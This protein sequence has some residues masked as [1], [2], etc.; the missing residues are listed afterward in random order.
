MSAPGPTSKFCAFGLNLQIYYAMSCLKVRKSPVASVHLDYLRCLAF[1]LLVAQLRVDPQSPGCSA[2]SCLVLGLLC[3]QMSRPS[4][5]SLFWV[6]MMAPLRPQYR[7]G[8]KV[9]FH[10]AASTFSNVCAS[11]THRV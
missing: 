5:A 6:V 4:Q 10:S 9:I 1:E 7:S 3:L 11:R 8:L 2:S